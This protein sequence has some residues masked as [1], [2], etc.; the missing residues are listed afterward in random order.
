MKKALHLVLFLL[1][2]TSG[3]YAQITSPVIRANFGVDAD[4]RSN[5]FNGLVQSGND[6]WFTLPGSVGTGKFV[7]DT[8][9]AAA[10]TARYPG[11]IPFRRTTF[12]KGMSYP[13]FSVVN[14]RLLLDAAFVRDFHGDDSTVFASGASKN[15]DNPADWSCPVSQGI[16]DKNDILDIMVHVRRAGPNLTDS[17][18]MMG[19]MS[20]DNTTG[21]RYFDFEMYQTDITYDRPALKFTGY[22]PDAGHTSWQFDAAGNIIKAGDIIFS[23]EYQ[24]SS[25]TFIEARIWIDKASTSI[26]PQAFDWSGQ[27]DGAFSGA[28]Y[29]YAS[30]Q[31]KAGGTYYTGLQCANNTWGGP[32]S[33]ILQNDAIAT[34]YSAK[35]YVEFSVNLTKLGLD[36]VTSLE[37]DPCGAP[38]RRLLVKTRASASFTAQLK[39]FVAPFALFAVPKADVQTTTPYL[40]AQG[41]VAEIHVANPVSTSVYQWTTTNGNIISSATGPSIIVDTPGT[42][43]VTQY[44]LSGCSVYASDT[45]QVLP[46]PGCVILPVDFID[47]RGAY[48]NGV[49][50]L[51]WKVM[52]NESIQYFEIQ[53]SVDGI[54]FMAV[55]RV[56]KQPPEEGAV[57]YSFR[58]NIGTL[59]GSR[60]YY[61]LLIVNADHTI[62]YSHIISLL[63]NAA[64]DKVIIFP[65]PAKDVIQVQVSATINTKMRIDLLD[66]SGKRVVTYSTSV[67]KGNNVVV[68]DDL[69]G[70]PRGVYLA[71]IY[72]GDELYQ[73]KIL[74]MK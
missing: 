50:Q 67:Q 18:W 19:G 20:L 10:I 15:G 63:L 48:R 62:K 14:N 7:I 12:G 24:S 60:I 56:D 28:T 53:R 33:I 22:G 2:I 73:Q 51:N 71:I 35:Q 3:G 11:D 45:I 23:A 64:N 38:F 74:L 30:I 44:L 68:L 41:S 17:L 26:T 49:A 32:F 52:N 40:C 54:N 16:P 58:E 9:G 65:N 72:V 69:A 29:G 39:D 34:D 25:L 36:P 66:A 57:D 31:P 55:D 47:F 8:T 37:G 61:R 1:I 4:L 6:D 5:F 70:K 27:F 46:M 21:D 13:P 59:P 43:I 42:Y